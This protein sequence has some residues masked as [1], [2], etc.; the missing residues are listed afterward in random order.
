MKAINESIDQ[1]DERMGELRKESAELREYKT[2]DSKCRALEAS[3]V[4]LE[5]Q[6]TRNALGNIDTT[7]SS[8]AGS[9]E[10]L[11]IEQRKIDDELKKKR[12][13]L[14]SSE[15]EMKKA[16]SDLEYYEKERMDVMSRIARLEFEAGE[17]REQ[18]A[19]QAEERKHLE[20]EAKKLEEELE[21]SNAELQKSK[22]AIASTIE[23]AETSH[24]E[25]LR[26]EQQLKVKMS[27]EALGQRFKSKEEYN[28]WIDSELE[29]IDKDIKRKE[30]NLKR[31]QRTIA[32][33]QKNQQRASDGLKEKEEQERKQAETERTFTSRAAMDQLQIEQERAVSKQKDLWQ[34]ENTLVLASEELTDEI[35]QAER[36]VG[37]KQSKDVM[38]G[39]AFIKKIMAEQRKE[40]RNRR[41]K[42]D[43][44]NNDNERVG[45]RKRRNT[46][47]ATTTT[48]SSS[49]SSVSSMLNPG[50]GVG[51]GEDNNDDN[52]DEDDI[53]EIFED[54]EL[55]KR[56]C[57]YG[58]VLDL[59]EVDER[60]RIAAEVIAGPRYYLYI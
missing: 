4:D 32:E 39:L 46:S 2:I 17:A 33:L 49:S 3:I 29:K 54:E 55:N 42:E 9:L 44:D 22:E 36:V 53:Q 10:D 52:N 43:G 23:E 6:Q 8:L 20:E 30:E 15:L 34:R 56:G 13:S 12:E 27:K 5:L 47:T 31:L 58:T 14:R 41:R 18:A 38:N 48:S 37:A 59:I 7:R 26:A 40:R 24:G 11:H 45:G 50:E 25:R 51:E 57:I 1:L 28:R 19:A 35:N 60:D 16:Q 21:K